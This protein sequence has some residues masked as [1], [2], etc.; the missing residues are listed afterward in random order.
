MRGLYGWPAGRRAKWVVIAAWIGLVVACSPWASTLFSSTND[1]LVS[2]LSQ[3][4]ESTRVEELKKQFTGNAGDRLVVVYERLDGITA[5]DRAKAQADLDRLLARYPVGDRVAQSRLNP[6]PDGKALT[7]GVDVP[8]GDPAD[9]G[10]NTQRAVDDARALVGTGADGLTVRVGGP[11][12]VLADQLDSF[13]GLHTTVLIATVAIVAILL[14]LIYRSPFLWLV[15]LLTVAIAAQGGQAVASAIAQYTDLTVTS[16]SAFVLVVLI[17]GAGTDYALLLIARYREELRR[18]DDHHEALNEALRRCGPAVVT[19]AATVGVALLCLLAAGLNSHRA[20]GPVGLGGIAFALLAT[21]TLLPALLAVLGRG[22]LWPSVPRPGA[23]GAAAL[24]TVAAHRGWERVA[25][26]LARRPRRAWV[27][28]LVV[29]GVMCGGLFT[30]NLGLREVD[31]FTERPES[32]AAQETLQAHYSPGI[33][34]TLQVVSSAPRVDQV[35]Q[36]VRQ[37]PGVARAVVAGRNDVVALVNANLEYAPDS[38]E[39]YDTITVLRDRVRQVPDAD[40]AVGGHSAILVDLGESNL[41]DAMVI[42]PMI[43]GVIL[44]VLCL[45][46]RSTV[47]PLVLIGTAAV[48]FAAALGLCTVVF[49]L[50]FGFGGVDATLLVQAFVF[51]VALGVDYNIFLISRVQEEA[52]RH[53][54]ALGT[55]RA[56]VTTSGVIT[57]AGVVLAATFAV[58]VALPLVAWVQVGFLVAVGVLLDTLVIRTVLVP[59][60]TM[61]LGRSVWWPGARSRLPD[62]GDR[63]RGGPGELV[64]TTGGPVT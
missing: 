51:L 61:D 27:G 60:L 45:V 57:S 18:H 29:L 19:S 3:G 43:L 6:S 41:R 36:V 1:N 13:G 23:R 63:P 48:S 32:V 62:R 64:D 47:A 58:L 15:P 49:Q 20:L 39:E 55:R 46:L 28:T 25:T 56:L 34:R 38:P 50:G 4:S 37:T 5:N 42:I 31:G 21:L 16:G 9:Q 11:A 2:Y 53:G 30:M 54:T 59:A 35:L 52:R 26:A 17:Y 12:G 22:L 14:L 33:T 7:F 24:G 40:P 10:E 8:A 44:L